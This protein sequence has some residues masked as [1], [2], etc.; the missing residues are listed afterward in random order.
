M[1]TAAVRVYVGDV[2]GQAIGELEQFLK[3]GDIAPGFAGAAMDRAPAADICCGLYCKR[4]CLGGEWIMASEELYSQ[5][6][7]I[8]GGVAGDPDFF[9]FRIKAGHALPRDQR[10]TRSRR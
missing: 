9:F 5:S 8:E 2:D 3:T 4:G 1:L 6:A 10:V 7:V